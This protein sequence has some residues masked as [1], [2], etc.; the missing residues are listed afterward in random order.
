MLIIEDCQLKVVEC[1]GCVWNQCKM[2]NKLLHMLLCQ[3]SHAGA[4]YKISILVLKYVCLNKLNYSGSKCSTWVKDMN[5]PRAV[6]RIEWL[7]KA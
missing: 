4:Y 7:I 5:E 2:K 1:V 6:P 3:Y